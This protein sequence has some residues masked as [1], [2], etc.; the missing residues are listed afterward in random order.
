MTQI[1][2]GLLGGFLKTPFGLMTLGALGLAVFGAWM[3]HDGR[4]ESG[5]IITAQ[6]IELQN[7]RDQ[8]DQDATRLARL[9]QA[10]LADEQK[11]A[12]L[13]EQGNRHEDQNPRGADPCRIRVDR[14]R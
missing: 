3:K 6:R 8:A 14:L 12:R 1:L 13:I 11:I 4:R 7:L 9:E 10:R 2:V 5:T